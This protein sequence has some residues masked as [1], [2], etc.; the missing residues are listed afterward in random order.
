M[1]VI[2]IKKHVPSGTIILNRPDRRNA[3][4]R[5]VMSDLLQALEDFHTERRVRAVILTGAGEAFCAGMDLS[6]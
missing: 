3:L 1:A 2:E 6:K 4:S 5:E